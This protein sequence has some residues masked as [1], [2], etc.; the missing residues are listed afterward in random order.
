MAR[1]ASPSRPIFRRLT[2]RRSAIAGIVSVALVVTGSITTYAVVQKFVPPTPLTVAQLPPLPVPP[3]QVQG[4]SALTADGGIRDSAVSVLSAPRPPKAFTPKDAKSSFNAFTS[5]VASR[6]TFDTIYSNADG[7][8]TEQSSAEPMNFQNATGAW[9]PINTTVSQV[10]SGGFTVDDHPLS[11]QFAAKSG[12]SSDYSVAA[13]SAVVSFSLVGEGSVAAAT[14]SATD[15][16]ERGGPVKSAV[17][18]PGVLPGQ[19]LV[20][21]VTKT[22]VDESI[23]LGTASSTAPSWTW[24]VHAPGLTLTTVDGD[25]DYTDA[26]GVVQLVTPIP[27]MWDSSGVTG[28]AQPVIT[29][30]PYTLAQAKDG[31]WTVTL[32]PDP[33]WLSSPDRVYP[34]FVDPSTLDADSTGE[35]SFE[36]NGTEV[37]GVTWMGNSRAGGD[38]Y[39]RTVESYPYSGVFGDEVLGADLVLSYAGSGTTTAQPGTVYAPTGYAYS[40]L[41]PNL[42]AFTVTSGSGYGVASSAALTSQIRGYVDGGVSGRA[43]GILGNEVAGSYTYKS[44][45]A[46]LQIEYESKP[47]VTRATETLPDGIVTSPNMGAGTGPANPVLQVTATDPSGGGLNYVYYISTTSS[48]TTDSSPTWKSSPTSSDIVSKPSSVHLVAGTRYY[49]Q[50]QA[51]DEYGYTATS[52]VYSWTPTSSPTLVSSTADTPLDKSIV[53]TTTPTLTAPVATDTNSEPLTYYI[54]VTSGADG[55]SGEVIQ[56]PAL[57]PSDGSNSD[58]VV[59]W[60]PPTGTLQDGAS[61]TWEEVV[62]D[63]YDDWLPSLNQVTINLRVTNSG[64]APTDS[65]GGVSINLANGNVSTSFSSRTVSTLGGAM[66][67]GFNYNSE[68]VSNAGLTGTYYSYTSNPSG[69]NPA[70]SFTASG[71]AQVLQ[72]TDPNIGFNW[73]ST[74]PSPSVP[75]GGYLA[76]WTGSINP[77]NISSSTTYQFGFQ[78]TGSAALYFGSTDAI[79]QWSGGIVGATDWGPSTSNLTVAAGGATGTLNGSSV[80]FPLAVTVDYFVTAPAATG[81]ASG[82]VNLVTQVSGSPST[83]QVVPANWF[84]KSTTFLPSG[85]ASSAPIAGDSGDIARADVHEGYITFTDTSGGEHT[86]IKSSTGT[87]YTPP[88]GENGV[89]A[90][91]SS[92]KLTFTDDAGTNY[93]F[94]TSGQVSLVSTPEDA[95]NPAEPIAIYSGQLL[96]ALA[97]PLSKS[98]STYSR[99]ITFQYSTAAGGNPACTAPASP[100]EVAP[101]GMIC[102]MNY[103]DGSSSQLLY[104]INDQLAELIDPGTVVTNFQYGWAGSPNG[105]SQQL[106][107]THFRNSLA[108]DV[109]MHNAI[110]NPT[111]AFETTIAYD[112]TTGYATSVKLPAP[113][114]VTTAVQ[115]QKIYT[116]STHDPATTGGTS[117]V[118]EGGLTVP[119]TAPSD[120]HARTVT[121]DTGLRTVTNMSALGLTSSDVWDQHDD[122]LGSIDPAGVESSTQYDSQFR[123]VSSYGP[124]P[125]SCFNTT[126][127]VLLGTCTTT[128]AHSAIT[129]DGGMAGLNVAYYGNQN[130]AGIPVAYSLGVGTSDGTVNQTWT[131]VP[132]SGVPTVWSAMLTGTVT[133]PTTG[134]YTLSLA[135]DYTSAL[136]VNDLLVSSVNTTGATTT[137][138]FQATA[139]KPVRI[140]IDYSHNAGSA[141]LSLSWTPS[142]GSS[143][144]VPGADLSPDYS[145]VTSTVADDSSAVT[146]ATVPAS[147]ETDTSYAPAP[148]LGQATSTIVDPGTGHFKLTSAA[149]YESSSSLY[150]RQLTSKKPSGTSTTSTNTYYTA[151][152]TIATGLGLTGTVC[153]LPVSTPQY[154]MLA[155]STGPAP[156]SGAARVTDYVYDLLGRVVGAKST[157]QSTWTCSTLDARGR[158]TSVAYPDRTVSTDHAVGGDPLTSSVT[159]PTGTITSVTDLI[160]RTVSSSDVWGTVTSNTYNR[161]NQLLSSTVTPPSG[162]GTSPQVL[163]YGY[164]VDGGLTEEDLNSSVIAVPSYDAAGRLAAVSYPSGSGDVGNGSALSS[165][166]YDPSTGALDAESWGFASGQ[167]AFT[168]TDT[169][170]QSG[171]VLDDY[172]TTGTTHYTRLYSYDAA[173]RLTRA[174]VHDNTLTY[175]FSASGGCGV[176][177]AAGADGNRVGFTDTPTSS[178]PNYGNPFTVTYCYD[179]ADRLTGDSVSGAPSGSSP[180]LAGALSSSGSSPSLVYDAEGDITTLADQLMVYDQE[181]RHVSTTTTA[182]PATTVTYTR[183]ASDAVVGME[184]NIVGGTD[185]TVRYSGGGGIQFTLNSSGAVQEESLSLPGGV[186]VSI[187]GSSMSSPQVWSYPDLHGDVT[188]TTDGAG[189]RTGPFAMYDP[190]GDPLDLTTDLIGTTAAN[191]Q[192]PDNTTTA[193]A[194]YGWEG[195][196]GKQ[197][198]HTGDIATIEM[199]AR[200]YI[201]LLGRF[202]T[203]DPVPGG[204]ANDYNYP[205]DPINGN[206][207]SGQM[208]LIDG[209][210]TLTRATRGGRTPPCMLVGLPC[211]K[212]AVKA[213]RQVWNWI[214]K[215]VGFGGELCVVIVCGD[216]SSAS[217]H[218]AFKHGSV[219]IGVGVKEGV[220]L[221]G[222]GSTS[223][224]ISKSGNTT[225]FGYTAVDCAALFVH[226]G[227]TNYWGG[228]QDHTAGVVTGEEVGCSIGV[229]W[230]W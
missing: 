170:S 61:Y 221:G 27:T 28:E 216:V 116:Y 47:T 73:G 227:T 159:D 120:G 217:V 191:D 210:V 64:P 72:R 125:S 16:G 1:H 18:Y 173:G 46:T 229:S 30:V 21:Q 107:L 213:G 184:T 17:E 182:S 175:S 113:D 69:T 186:S 134:T 204:N 209:S 86:Y 87:G 99:E 32:T 133:F 189:V 190:F 10:S 81:V 91:D 135:A 115:P 165:V 212:G 23:V 50:V 147:M 94:A 31:D 67:F 224:T 65:A 84:T 12:G 43:L 13:G 52:S 142:G 15:L 79:N 29:N 153:G 106:V 128:P 225:G 45:D 83:L 167:S 98:G 198:Q 77:P 121:F 56:S 82:N 137:G 9:T 85:W 168:D 208:N 100:Y 63:V 96:T 160:G 166:G 71:V 151:A 93:Q 127:A 2:G 80:A 68:T 132:V 101:A 193:G 158:V 90:Y 88:T 219:G 199:G 109:I 230:T 89:V 195:Q 144:I 48:P 180:L 154:G 187:Q 114:G 76:Q 138:L 74:P 207:L 164:N 131:G 179:F 185:K 3:P 181:S 205:N 59:S 201:P 122:L 20:Y 75:V 197:Y 178:N 161:L 119:T 146:G 124:A 117:Y 214:L 202:L 42:A 169:F 54:R 58:S 176:N 129:Y 145:L 102:Q 148:W 156:A 105:S 38:T 37:D 25:I 139:G 103:P 19:D 62:N 49:W 162:S 33:T 188:V 51:T 226:G 203:V 177:T 183:D 174:G 70:T 126:T 97:D 35:R 141:N 152:D 95:K 150:D 123:P 206:D 171:Q 215:N 40:D 194:S 112:T 57:T 55:Q 22:G 60:S 34:V 155:Y 172:L 26:K 53:A 196:H 222:G 5:S 36:S 110:T 11:P 44:L 66:G 143:V 218:D 192:V 92:G 140:Q 118:D 163:A 24:D 6:S 211:P 200:Q 220:R 157:G 8:Q 78:G 39:W 149:T 130:R 14:P 111:Y 223:V 104:D 108:N 136:F 228:G 41:G 7:T 4:G